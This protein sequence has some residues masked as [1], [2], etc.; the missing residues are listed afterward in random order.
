MLSHSPEMSFFT[1]QN[2]FVVQPYNK[3]KS[4]FWKVAV[5]I[6]TSANDR[7]YEK[8]LRREEKKNNGHSKGNC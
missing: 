8:K 4:D 2:G 7:A 1:M 3:Q 5:F 6:Y